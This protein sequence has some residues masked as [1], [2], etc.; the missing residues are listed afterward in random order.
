MQIANM[1][2]ASPNPELAGAI[3]RIDLGALRHNYKKLSAKAGVECGA[4]IKGEAYGVGMAETGAA[5]WQAGCRKFFVARPEEGGSLRNV[6]RDAEI[7]VLDGLYP[8]A[9][10]YYV[11]HGLRPALTSLAQAEDWARHGKGKPCA[12]HVDTGINRAGF[13]MR[14][15]LALAENAPLNY[16][17]NIALMMSHLACADSPKHPM[18]RKQLE[19]FKYVKS[20]YPHVP[21]S[22]ANSSGIYLGKSY[23]LDMARPGVALYG[24]NPVL[25]KKNPMKPVVQLMA[26]V[27]QVRGLRKGETVGYSA[28]WKAPRDSRIAILAAGYRD[29]IPRKLSSSKPEGL[30][31]VWLG[32]RRCPIIGRVSMDMMCVDVSAAKNVL[33]GDEAEIFGKH[34]SIDEAAGWASTIS[35]E[36]FTHLG[37]RYARTYAGL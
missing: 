34:I 28:T 35:Y 6:L 30:A 21:A 9:A 11:M 23:S 2:A 37:T 18:N 5:L 3:L 4:A 36:L 15:F 10:D 8:R 33:V 12:L 16:K 32:N 7:Y 26:K 1:S 20:F 31:Q 22:L 27:L 19:R 13:D 24:G 17:L 25:P 29:G 14:E